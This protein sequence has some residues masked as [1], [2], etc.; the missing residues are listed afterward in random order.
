MKVVLVLFSQ[1]LEVTNNSTSECST[2][3][4]FVAYTKK[5]KLVFQINIDSKYQHNFLFKKVHTRLYCLMKLRSFDVSHNILQFYFLHFPFQVCLLLD[6]S[7]V[8]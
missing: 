6:V 3:L 4:T 1:N 2:H 7:A 5:M 8:V